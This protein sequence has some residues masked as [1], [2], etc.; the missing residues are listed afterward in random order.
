MKSKRNNPTIVLVEFYSDGHFPTYLKAFAK[1]LLQMGHNLIVLCPEAVGLN[2]WINRNCPAYSGKIKIYPISK[3]RLSD[4]GTVKIRSI[5]NSVRRWEITAEMI[6][7]LIKDT[8]RQP[9]LIFFDYVDDFLNILVPCS[10]ID[11][12]FPYPWSGLYF[13]PSHLRIKSGYSLIQKGLLE[14]DHLLSSKYCRS[15]AVLDEGI[16]AHLRNKPGVRKV[17]LFPD[18]SDNTMPDENYGPAAEI[19]LKANGRKIVGMLGSLQKR[20]GI[21]TLLE[22]SQ[23]YKDANLF[24]I[25][26]GNLDETGFTPGELRH[27]NNLI[28]APPD[29]C[30]FHNSYIP[31]GAMFNAVVVL[32]DVLFA[33]YENFYHSSNILTKAANFRKW[34]VVGKGYCMA[35]RVKKFRLGLSVDAGDVAACFEALRDLSGGASG[36]QPDYTG[37]MEL[38]SESRLREAFAAVVG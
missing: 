34:V 21:L 7:D 2:E 35:E 29:N 19:R 1:V 25:F 16:I 26:C 11:R 12:I 5:I 9:D 38:H 23:R 30:F 8:G 33:V 13:H 36:L 6:R 31:D 4:F 27:I 22:L 24:Y 18:I 10:F 17:S 20:K 15:I 32:C 28:G 3:P 37:Y 14:R